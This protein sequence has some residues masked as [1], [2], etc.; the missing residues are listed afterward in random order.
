M[1]LL[2]WETV[3]FLG[4]EVYHMSRAA[5]D[6]GVLLDACFYGIPSMAA[7]VRVMSS[8]FMFVFHTLFLGP[9]SSLASDAA[10]FFG[11]MQFHFFHMLLCT[12][13]LVHYLWTA[14][15]R[16]ART[17]AYYWTCFIFHTGIVWF[18]TSGITV[19]VR[20]QLGHVPGNNA[21]VAVPP[22]IPAAPDQDAV[23]MAIAAARA[24][25]AAAAA[26]LA[27]HRRSGASSPRSSP[28]F[29]SPQRGS[30]R[31]SSRRDSA[32]GRE[33]LVENVSES[34]R[35]PEERSVRGVLGSVTQ[36][37]SGSSVSTSSKTALVPYVERQLTPRN[38]APGQPELHDDAQQCRTPN[39][40]GASVGSPAVHV[41]TSTPSEPIA[42]KARANS[43]PPNKPE[44]PAKVGVEGHVHNSVLVPSAEVV[45]GSVEG[46][47]A[48]LATAGGRLQS[49][50][51]VEDFDSAP[52]ASTKGSA[53]TFSYGSSEMV[54][55]L[56]ESS[57]KC[58]NAVKKAGK[59]PAEPHDPSLPGPSCSRAQDA[60]KT[61]WETPREL[62]AKQS[63]ATSRKN[64][65]P[66][67]PF[68]SPTEA[69]GASFSGS[70]PENAPDARAPRGS[71][72][73]SASKKQSP[74][75]SRKSSVSDNP[76]S[77]PATTAPGSFSGSPSGCLQDPAEKIP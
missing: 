76:T 77:K 38:N 34:T 40:P 65:S 41:L 50:T 28:R 29:G 74:T 27:R 15:K 59:S 17:D 14:Q 35:L 25:D 10:I 46:A 32:F 4:D 72:G 37:L 30:S 73:E 23:A 66:G 26:R 56:D 67:S 31:S 11:D 57:V 7:M 20:V 24:A 9:R 18:Y 62:S 71:S 5:S 63:L 36:T 39:A 69:Q 64:S 44:I 54:L 52:R 61:P 51:T 16:Q 13:K 12:W 60:V 8:L 68:Q 47:S 33:P 70:P 22:P 45:C 21:P 58:P 6:L 53:A 3:F 49:P 55:D 1:S 48:G 43:D 19:S 42:S 75:V 2:R